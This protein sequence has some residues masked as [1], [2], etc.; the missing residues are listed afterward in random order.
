MTDTL[1]GWD[2]CELFFKP[3]QGIFFFFF[4]TFL[5]QTEQGLG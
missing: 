5:I 3:L 2:L 1:V 4:F